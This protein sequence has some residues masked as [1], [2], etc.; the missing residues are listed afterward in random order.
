MAGASRRRRG[1]LGPHA[2]DGA[3]VTP[4]ANR[5]HHLRR[6]RHDAVSAGLAA[7][8]NVRRA[9]ETPP[10][11]NRTALVS[12]SWL[13]LAAADGDEHPVAVRRVGRRRPSGGRSPRSSASRHKEEPPAIHG[14]EAAALQGRPVRTSMLRQRHCWQVTRAAARSAAAERLRPSSRARK[15]AASPAESRR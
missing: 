1:G 5:S 14:V 4:G 12:P 6:E 2:P 10:F 15:H 8:R 9:R 7:A 3:A 13:V 11:T